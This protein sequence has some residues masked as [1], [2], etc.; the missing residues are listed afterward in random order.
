MSES[1]CKWASLLMLCAPGSTGARC[2]GRVFQQLPGATLGSGKF[3]MIPD[4]DQSDTA[5]NATESPGGKASA[6][7]AL[8]SEKSFG[9]CCGLFDKPAYSDPSTWLLLLVWILQAFDSS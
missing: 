5:P 6:L 9:G 2:A 8:L 7:S 3:L 4:V 1:L